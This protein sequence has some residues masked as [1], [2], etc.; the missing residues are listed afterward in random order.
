MS[1]SLLSGSV[2]ELTTNRLL[3]DDLWVPADPQAL[4]PGLKGTLV[5]NAPGAAAS[6]S[7]LTQ[8]IQQIGSEDMRFVYWSEHQPSRV[9]FGENIVAEVSFDLAAG[10]YAYG[11]IWLSPIKG[12]EL[13][14]CKFNPVRDNHCGP[15]EKLIY[16]GGSAYALAAW[17]G[18]VWIADSHGKLWK[19]HVGGDLD[20]TIALSFDSREL[21]PVFPGE[22]YAFAVFDGALFAGH[23]PSGQLVR[24]HSDGISQNQWLLFGSVLGHPGASTNP[25]TVSEIEVQSLLVHAG[26]LWAGVYPWGE[27]YPILPSG[28]LARHPYR[29]FQGKRENMP[30][31]PYADKLL[32]EAVRIAPGSIGTCSFNGSFEAF[33][34]QGRE[35]EAFVRDCLDRLGG[36]ISKTDWGQRIPSQTLDRSGVYLATGNRMNHSWLGTRDRSI[37]SESQLEDYGRIWRIVLPG[38]SAM[39]FSW[40][41]SGRY[42]LSVSITKSGRIRLTDASGQSIESRP[43]TPSDM[44]CV[45]IGTGSFGYAP[46]RLVLS[47]SSFPSCP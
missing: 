35:N 22:F 11:H 30:P 8:S 14:R 24:L 15:M 34:E 40:P 26:T 46:G 45:R 33:L 36:Y 29:F 18:G 1:L 43:D 12:G 31:F 21:D 6:Y 32:R 20:G 28:D 37:I 2:I 7:G 39:P 17:Q 47:G 19:T 10:L 44:A 4:R 16:P 27:L 5:R 38:T 13:W 9:V 3:D 41:E 42:R 23:Y 25:L